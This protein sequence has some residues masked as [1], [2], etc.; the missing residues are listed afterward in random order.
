[1]F[2][3]MVKSNSQVQGCI[4]GNR[5][6]SKNLVRY[7]NPLSLY[8]K[9]DY[10]KIIVNYMYCWY[11]FWDTLF[12]KK[13]SFQLDTI[14]LEPMLYKTSSKHSLMWGEENIY[15]FA[16]NPWSCNC[17]NIKTIQEFLNKYS[18]LIEDIEYMKCTE[19]DCALLYLDYKVPGV[20]KMPCLKH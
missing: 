7:V 13:F 4:G 19:C 14:T 5:R 10:F 3:A 20:Q 2:I 17:H 16:D 9:L 6:V 18:N 11:C 15:Y 12:F 8:K 1:M